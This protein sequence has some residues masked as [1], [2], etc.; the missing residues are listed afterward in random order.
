MMKQG[1]TVMI[2]C[3]QF[4]PRQRLAGAQATT[5]IRYGSSWGGPRQFSA[6][7]RRTWRRGYHGPG[8]SR[9]EG[10][11][12]SGSRPLAATR[13]GGRCQEPPKA[14]NVI[15]KEETPEL[16]THVLKIVVCQKLL[17]TQNQ[18]V[19]VTA[20]GWRR[21]SKSVGDKSVLTGQKRRG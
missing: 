18:S 3:I 11:S 10:R 15:V 20:E 17:S 1:S 9:L 12:P 14:L 7:R 16:A 13:I 21:T 4:L 8:A 6:L 2:P 5:P 19:A